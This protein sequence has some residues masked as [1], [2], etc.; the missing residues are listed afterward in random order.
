MNSL[1]IK[2]E[3]A[4]GEVLHEVK[5]SFKNEKVTLLE[6]ITQRVQQEVEAYNKKLPSIFHGLIQPSE[7][8][9][10]L[11]GYKMKKK[12]KVDAE[13]QVLTALAA[14]KANGFFVLVDNHQAEELDELIMVKPSTVVSFVKLTPLVGG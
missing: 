13:K 9:R 8:E 14:F 11:N 2:D 5:L 7:A 12:V 4:T 10:A 6:I 3:S 1:L